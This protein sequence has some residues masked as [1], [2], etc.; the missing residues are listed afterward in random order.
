MKT[1]GYFKARLWD[2]FQSVLGGDTEKKRAI[3]EHVRLPARILEVGCATGNVADAFRDSEYVGVDVDGGAIAVARRKFPQGNYTFQCLDILNDP[4]LE[5]EGFDYVLISH[6]A[7]HLPDEYFG[8]LIHRSAELL[9]EGGELVVLDMV[10]PEPQEPWT[11]QFYYKLDRGRYFR[12]LR[13]FAELLSGQQHLEE[14]TFHVIK[15]SKFG[16]EII[17]EVLIR[18]RRIRV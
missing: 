14:P 13:E 2:G 5:P 8:R 6:T 12:N 17:D 3:L 1:F 11:K 18:A 4:F 10:R 15:S 7:H 16:V 9:R